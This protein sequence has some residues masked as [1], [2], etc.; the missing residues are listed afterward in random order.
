MEDQRTA[1]WPSPEHPQRRVPQSS[2]HSIPSEDVNRIS[3]GLKTSEI[4]PLSENE[5]VLSHL[6]PSNA[7]TFATTA[8]APTAI[9]RY[10][11]MDSGSA[12][13]ASPV[14][15]AAGKLRTRGVK[16]PDP[17]NVLKLRSSFRQLQMGRTSPVI[18]VRAMAVPADTTTIPNDRTSRKELAMLTTA[19]ATDASAQ[20]FISPVTSGISELPRRMVSSKTQ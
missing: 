5:P 11:P 10:Q 19:S 15:A 9:R 14:R 17:K 16:T 13:A 6:G 12:N 4:N 18:N 1:Q 7:Q 20:V 3:S 8:S 2:P